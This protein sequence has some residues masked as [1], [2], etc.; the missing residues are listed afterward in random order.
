MTEQADWSHT[1]GD[2]AVGS[3]SRDLL[4]G[5]SRRM[6]PRRPSPRPAGFTSSDLPSMGPLT[7]FMLLQA[8][9]TQRGE[10]W[11]GTH[12]WVTP[13]NSPV[14]DGVPLPWKTKPRP[15]DFGLPLFGTTFEAMI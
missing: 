8:R 6:G 2:P 4:G 12:P 5:T 7:H 13:Q 3:L 1:P 9:G 14:I 11:P 15:L 10:R